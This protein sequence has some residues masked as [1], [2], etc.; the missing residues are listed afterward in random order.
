MQ[1]PF[2]RE[3]YEYF[4]VGRIVLPQL[5]VHLL[6]RLLLPHVVAT[7]GLVRQNVSFFCPD[8]ILYGSYELDYQ[9]EK[10]DEYLAGS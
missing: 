9:V 7:D 3:G 1:H 5:T 6:S 2:V 4:L 10:R 8:D